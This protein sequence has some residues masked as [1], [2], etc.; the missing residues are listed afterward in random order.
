MTCCFVCLCTHISAGGSGAANEKEEGEVPTAGVEKEEEKKE[1]EE[2]EEEGEEGEIEEGEASPD[3]DS[4]QRKTRHEYEELVAGCVQTYGE[5][6]FVR[7]HVDMLVGYIVAGS[8]SVA[9]KIVSDGPTKVID[10]Q[11]VEFIKVRAH[12][13]PLFLLAHTNL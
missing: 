8:E 1:G 3:N 5:I 12:V 11:V 9:D 7:A 6:T 10:G 13:F 2:E 4:N